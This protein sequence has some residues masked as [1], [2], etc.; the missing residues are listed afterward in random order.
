V[1]I[2]GFDDV[3]LSDTVRPGLTVVAQDAAELG[4]VAAE[5]P[6][7]RIEGSRAPTRLITVPTRLVAR[8]SGELPPPTR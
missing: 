1:A 7:E 6:L 4:R 2:V 8:G 3:T 5:L